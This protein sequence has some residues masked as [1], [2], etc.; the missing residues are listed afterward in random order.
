MT[1]VETYRALNRLARNRRRP[2]EEILTLYAL[3]R[4]LGRLVQTRFKDDFVLKGGVLMAAY[5]LR[6]PTRDIDVAAV[7][8]TLDQEHLTSMIEAVAAVPADDGLTL[9]ATSLTFTTIRDEH[10][11]SGLRISLVV[12]L[13]TAKL[14]VRLDVSTGDPIVPEPQTVVLPGLLGDDVEIA[15]YPLE[16]VVAEK[17]VT[18]LQRGT[19]STR[20]RDFMDLG[21]F[22]RTSSFDAARLL[23]SIEKVAAHRQVDLR[24]LEDVVAG[25]PE[26]AQRPWTLWRRKTRIDDG[27]HEAF[28]DQLGDVLGFVGPL[29]A[30]QITGGTWD[31]NAREWITPP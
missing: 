30:G 3:E 9:D 6:R 15:G 27:V 18:I 23:E 20:W 5:D 19:T 11:Y 10:E 12:G 1:A 7:D 25:Y 8:L 29:F 24:P 31:P 13:Y 2:F 22:A 28:A 26:I 17:S 14:P 21:N 16:L 4:I